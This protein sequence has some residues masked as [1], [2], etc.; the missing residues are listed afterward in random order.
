MNNHFCGHDYKGCFLNFDSINQS[1]IRKHTAQIC[2]CYKMHVLVALFLFCTQL[3]SAEMLLLSIALLT[4]GQHLVCVYS[5]C[6]KADCSSLL[7]N[8][9][10]TTS[11]REGS[12]LF[13]DLAAFLVVRYGWCSAIAKLLPKLQNAYHGCEDEQP[14]FASGGIP[15][16]RSGT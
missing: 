15:A 7:I 8:L 6:T 5:F 11:Q 16:E 1:V 3:L 14:V 12:V 9:P 4:F 2:V 13:C 10:G